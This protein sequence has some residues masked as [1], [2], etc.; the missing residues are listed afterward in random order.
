MS[1]SKSNSDLRIYAWAPRSEVVYIQAVID[2]YEGLAR[3]RTER[4]EGD[5][6]L[7]L[8]MSQESQREQL[9]DILQH[10]NSEISGSNIEYI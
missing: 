1:A 3:V 2:A 6:S 7:I 8:F 10:L 5:K 9:F 4:H